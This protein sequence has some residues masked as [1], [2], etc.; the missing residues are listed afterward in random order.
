[1][2]STRH[3]ARDLVNVKDGEIS[4][5]IFVNGDIYQ[6]EQERIFTR[7][8]LY[9]GHES[10]IKN[11][12]DFFVSKMGEES[13]ILTRDRAG[14]IHV[15]L[16]SCTHRGMKVCRYDEGN[17]KN[18]ICPYH[19]WSFGTDGELIGVQDYENAY[20]PPFDKSKWGLIE[21]AQ[22]TNYLGTIWATWDKN[23]P[24]F[25]D[26][27]G[28]AKFALD[29]GLCAWDGGDGGTELLGSVQK[30]IVPCNWKFIAENF[31]GDL[32]HA[33]SHRSVDMVRLGPSGEEGRRDDYGRLIL[34]AFPE[35][36]GI[37]YGVV[38]L[39]KTR[40][41]YA[42]SPATSA[43][44]QQC[45]ERRLKNRGDLAGTCPIVGTMFPNMSFHAQQPR[46]ILVSHPLSANRT[47]MW[48]VYFVDKEAPDEVKQFLRDY[49]VQYSGPA[50]MTEQDDMENWNYATEASSGII[51]R[52][53]PYH[54]K[55]GLGA[56]GTH[57]IIPGIVTEQP[58]TSEQNPRAL[59]RRWA[60][61]M[62]TETWAEL[63]DARAVQD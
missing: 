42:S 1:M 18:F 59:Y 46:A 33:T 8:W 52:R 38:P 21:V 7:A 17:T 32:L 40:T 20:K 12:G 31:S 55:A 50:G 19:A 41:E 37:F 24:S 14:K 23:A 61:Y 34:N 29:E 54:Y 25:E 39:D 10:Q 26:Y 62:D 36:H 28:G 2:K 27:L 22:I 6:E 43:Y 45:W 4:R 56:E 3:S 51:A 9:I 48:R 11:P 13:V 35:G 60:E 5:E 57:D 15:F 63:L 16:N 58:V 49:Y 44:F 30:W 47:E 53:H